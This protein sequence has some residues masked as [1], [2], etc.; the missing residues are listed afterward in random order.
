VK[1]SQKAEISL[2]SLLVASLIVPIS[3]VLVAADYFFGHGLLKSVLPLNLDVVFLYALLLAT[4]HTVAS[5]FGFADKEYVLF[6]KRRLLVEVPLVLIA[7]TAFY[8]FFRSYAI[9]FYFLYTAY[10]QVSQRGGIGRFYFKSALPEFELWKWLTVAFTGIAYMYV[11]RTTF[12]FSNVIA[13]YAL[14][15]AGLLLLPIV[16][17][18][19]LMY[20]RIQNTSG[21][22]YL[23]T[24][25]GS[26][27]G[28][29]LLLMSGYPALAILCVRFE[30][31]IP[32]F[33]A[34]TTHDMNR[35]RD[36]K[37]NVLYK[38]LAF[39]KIP[40]YVLTPILAIILAF[41]LERTPYIVII[42]VILISTLHYYIEG[43]I[44]KRDSLHRKYLAFTG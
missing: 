28:E 34:Y 17:L 39:S 15:L 43:F 41:L 35:N 14:P 1:E 27:V 3:L 13:H 18:M 33:M 31:D 26:I 9:I 42:L 29:F 38:V 32:A 19:V 23:I 16:L 30:H 36:T 37:S 6:Y 20:R 25:A 10:H 4:P 40:V 24:L 11:A 2:H 7:F 12:S 22:L 8:Y 44:W 21:K 5:L